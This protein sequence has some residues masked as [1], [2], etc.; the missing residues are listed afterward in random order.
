MLDAAKFLSGVLCHYG[1]SLLGEFWKAPIQPLRRVSRLLSLVLIRKVS[2]ILQSIAYG[3]ILF[4]LGNYSNTFSVITVIAYMLG[5][6]IFGALVELPFLKHSLATVRSWALGTWVVMLLGLA[7]I[8]AAA[9][10]HLFL[11][12]LHE[13]L[14][15]WYIGSLVL[16]VAIPMLGMLLAVISNRYLRRKRMRLLRE[17]IGRQGTINIMKRPYGENEPHDGRPLNVIPE[18]STSRP[19]SSSLAGGER[20]E[21]AGAAERE[22][23][24]LLL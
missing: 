22:S 6:W 20:A 13:V 11:A 9:G 7:L 15:P 1:L 2:S 17:R 23:S 12:Q 3:F 18:T 21:P 5:L 14:W 4:T 8:L 10:Y 19:L 16:A 24:K